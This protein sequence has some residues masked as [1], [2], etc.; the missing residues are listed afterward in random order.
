MLVVLWFCLLLRR[1]LVLPLQVYPDPLSDV[2][3][4]LD[5]RGHGRVAHRRSRVGQQGHDLAQQ[6]GHRQAA[7]TSAVAEKKNRK[8]GLTSIKWDSVVVD[9][10]QSRAKMREDPESSII[11]TREWPQVENMVG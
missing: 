6:A 10:N 9:P 8:R 1:D 5:E 4:D 7:V 11:R 3:V 2:P